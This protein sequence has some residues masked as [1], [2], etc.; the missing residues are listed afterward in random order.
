MPDQ[1]G[2]SPLH[3]I[4]VRPY[5]RKNQL[6]KQEYAFLLLTSTDINVNEFNDEG[7][8]ALHIAVEVS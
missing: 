5:S 3:S 6:E 1:F 2:N 7:K 4:A 8:T